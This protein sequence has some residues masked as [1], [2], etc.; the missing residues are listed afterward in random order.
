MTM[1]GFDG[2]HEPIAIVGIGLRFPGENGTLDGFTEFLRRGGS[3]IVPVPE[4]RW[5]VP[6]YYDAAGGAGKTR[7]A[8]GGF[9][10]GVD[11]FDAGFFAISPREAAYLDP[12]QRLVLETTWEALESANLDPFTLPEGNGGVY[13]AVSTA[14]YVLEFDHLADEDLDGYMDTGIAPCAVAGRVSYF[15]GWQ[16]PSLTVDTGCSGS[17]STLHL[18]VQG[19]RARECDVALSGGA[20]VI[21]HPRNLV[22]FSQAGM[23]SADGRCKTFDD[24]ADGYGRSE[25]CGVFVLKRLSDAQRDGDTVLALVR[26]TAVRQDGASG[27]LTVP[28]GLAQTALMRRALAAAELT[29]ADVGYVEAHGTGTPLGDPIEMGAISAVFKHSHS[30]GNPVMVGSVK[31]NLGHMEAAAGVGGVIKAVLQLREHTIFPHINL[32]RPSRHIPWQRYP[33]RLPLTEQRWPEQPESGQP[34]SGQPRRAMVNAFGVAG[35][36]ASV[37]LEQ[38]PLPEPLPGE[39]PEATLFTVSAKTPTALRTL[40]TRYRVL[41]ADSP[42]VDLE[43]L[44]Y[45]T[46]VG[47]AHQAVR[48]AVEPTSVADLYARL[49]RAEDDTLEFARSGRVAFLFTGQGSQYA[50]MGRALYERHGV[51]RRHVDE[52]DTLFT[53][54]LGRS[55]RDL[56]L[57]NDPDGELDQT[58]CTQ[59]ALFMVEY[60]LA[61]LWMSW[62]VRPTVLVGHSIG[63]IV[64]ATIS[65]LFS[66]PDAVRVVAARGRLMQSVTAPGAM[67]AVR[68]EVERVRPLLAGTPDLSFAAF[69]SPQQCVVSGGRVSVAALVQRL[70]AQE[71]KARELSVSQA[72]HSPLMAEVTDRFRA[73]LAEVEFGEP[74]LELVSC[75][76]GRPA[77][78]DELADPEYWVRQLVE[79]VD[80]AA[81]MA[82]VLERGPHLLVEIGPASTLISAARQCGSPLGHQWAASLNPGESDDATLRKAL[83]RCYVAGQPVA[84]QAYHGDRPGRRI[85]LPGYPFERKRHWV[86]GARR[87]REATAHH[88]LLG[89]ENSTE[90]QRLA[91]ERQFSAHLALDGPAGLAGHVVAGQVTLPGAAYV[92]MVLAV[93]DV[94]F[95]ET[96]RAVRDVRI[97]EPLVLSEETPVEVRTRLRPTDNGEAAVEIHSGVLASGGPVER[98]HATAVLAAC[99]Q[100]QG[101]LAQVAVKLRARAE[102]TDGTPFSGAQLYAEFAQLGLAYT[103]GFQQIQSA[104]RL[105]DNTVVASLTGVEAAGL[106]HVPACV[107]DGAIQTAL[108]AAGLDHTYLPVGFDHLELGKK[109]RGQLTSVLAVVDGESEI[110]RTLTADLVVLDGDRVSITVQGLR[111][112]RVSTG[113][114][115]GVTGLPVV[116]ALYEHVADSDRGLVTT[117]DLAALANRAPAERLATIAVFLRAKVAAVLYFGSPDELPLNASFVE[118]GMDSLVTM[119]LKNA[120]EGVFKVPLSVVDLLENSDI[121]ALAAFLHGKLFEVTAQA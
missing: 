74:E 99:P 81:A 31:T 110:G 78:F 105:A 72:F 60:A 36:I 16:G 3:G 37:V 6:A 88:P 27:G 51:F 33:V 120:V 56:L 106:E 103:G 28:N 35:T 66:L 112:A 82:D 113:G 59:P 30:A 68:A 67:I 107:L 98:L 121:S 43:R 46:N 63:E 118:L 61:R 7:T 9:L 38:A 11:E 48:Y 84:W 41:L 101:A 5:D 116:N 15:L 76:T 29:P 19:L 32:Q 117:L 64:A 75:L 44:C 62:G 49:T 45:T 53:P 109:P 34:G 54:H 100:P 87:R 12:Q 104:I 10:S 18:A 50:G 119:E 42:D 20:N 40:I 4:D 93:Q 58:S 91:G 90:T 24:S 55:I 2:E 26:G 23:L 22:V 57:S 86:P 25:G 71:I 108:I 73:V 21:T 102:R 39:G 65:G 115:T 95:G 77:G 13:M 83:L 8:G 92:E 114:H 70:R 89:A 85:P 69:N 97:H 1:A 17:L 96:S 14:D 94:V 79:P 80:F 47:R 52:C 111:L